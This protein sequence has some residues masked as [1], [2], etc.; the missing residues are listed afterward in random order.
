MEAV[1]EN[2]RLVKA[3]SLKNQLWYKEDIEYLIK[4]ETFEDNSIKIQLESGKH[5]ISYPNIASL[6]KEWKIN[7]EIKTEQIEK[8]FQLRIYYKE[9]QPIVEHVNSGMSETDVIALI[10]V[11]KTSLVNG[12][13]RGK[14]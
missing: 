7:Q 12:L 4:I 5:V 1:K 2:T 3:T 11:V 13:I 9:G 10:E 8:Q 14:K 6:E